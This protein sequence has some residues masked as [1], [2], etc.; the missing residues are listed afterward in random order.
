MTR[1]LNR[2]LAILVGK[3]VGDALGAGTEF[4]TPEEIARRHGIVRG[5]T[6]GENPGFAPGEFTDDT[7][8]ALCILGGYWDML[9]RGDDLLEATLAR[10]LAWHDARPPDI[11][12][13]TRKSLLAA[14]HHGLAGGFAGWEQSGCSA[15]GNGALM[16]TLR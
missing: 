11:G 3:A 9:A 1:L 4:M 15:A 13:A 5:Y 10:F 6:Q 12:I 7:H 8:M 2:R 14:R 16:S